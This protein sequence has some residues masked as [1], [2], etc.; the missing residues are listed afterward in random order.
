MSRRLFD[1]ASDEGGKAFDRR[2]LARLLVYLRPYRRWVATS[3][4]LM[5]IGSL[6]QLAG[7]TIAQIAIDRYIDPGTAAGLDTAARLAGVSRMALLLLL[8]VVGGFGFQYLQLYLMNLTGQKA[9]LD[10]RSA[11]YAH[12]LHL[13]LAYYDR[14]SIGWIQTRLTNDVE[15]LNDMF[16]SGVVAIFGDIFM[17]TGIVAFMFVLDARLALVVVLILP[18]LLGGTLW[19]R[20][21]AREAYR[22]VRSRLGRLNAFMQENLMGIR[23]V[24]I[25]T[26]EKERLERFREANREYRDAHLRTI[27]F[28][29]LFFPGVDFISALV[30]TALIWFGGGWVLGGTLTFGVLYAFILYVQR[31][32]RPVRDL[33]E[34]YNIMQSAMAA[35]E[36]IF[37]LMDEPVTITAPP[38]PRRPD[39]L[40]GRIAFEEVWFRYPAGEGVIDGPTP[41]SADGAG[42]PDGERPW[43]L[44]DVTFAVEP[45]Q[46]VAIVGATGAG[47]T[48]VSSLLS[49]FYEVERGRITID[50]IDI[51][52]MDPQQ[53]RRIVG[54]V[55][56]DVF[57]FSGTIAENIGLHNPAIRPEMITRAAEHANADPFI[58]R[59][60]GAYDGEVHER[61]ATLS[62]GQRQ[63]LAFARTL[64][65]DPAILV[66][67]EATSSVDTETELL[68][69]DALARLMA[70]RTTL[71]IAHRL[72]TIQKA[73]RII[74]MHRG[75]IRESGTHRELLA[76]RGLY[77]CLYQLQYGGGPENQDTGSPIAGGQEAACGT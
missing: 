1:P 44:R 35:S 70:G 23:V 63:L 60:P 52:E 20:F 33:A 25:F 42:S 24:Q 55:Q 75:E 50:G 43:I 31:F 17:L 69:Q 65:F 64:A 11:L 28:Y 73:D 29:A 54:M 38:L 27:F 15:A 10:L 6:V 34:K 8:T 5:F 66:L 13:P 46:T 61:G 47:K 14:T 74:V 71:V 22:E 40:T 37:T 21:K 68:I 49:R 48:T 12:L 53:L 62:T 72:S 45:G 9:M 26:R 39:P 67:D 30:L 2:L 16:T 76:R 32:Y 77:W 41:V 19:F 7:P 18:V 57:L 3:V 51:R 36:R 59:L 58:R 56:Q 4:V